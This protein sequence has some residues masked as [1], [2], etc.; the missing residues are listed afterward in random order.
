MGDTGQISALSR[1]VSLACLCTEGLV[2]KAI[3]TSA[4]W[5]YAAIPGNGT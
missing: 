2:C 3:Y 5:V 4:L 1:P